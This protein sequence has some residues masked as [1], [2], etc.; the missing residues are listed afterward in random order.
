MAGVYRPGHPER[1]IL[2]LVV[3]HHFERCLGDEERRFEQEYGFL[4]AAPNSH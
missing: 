1:T 4:W 2:Y 3:F